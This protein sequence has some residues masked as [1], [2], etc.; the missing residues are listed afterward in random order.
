M[1]LALAYELTRR[2]T[3]DVL[4]LERAYL[5]AGASGRNG[6]G[7]RAQWATPTMIRLARR[8]LELCDRFA[9]DGGERLFR[10][11]DTC[12]SP[13]PLSRWRASRRTRS[14]TGGRGSARA[15]S[16]APRP[17]TW[18][19]SSTPALSRRVVQPGRRRGVPLAVPVGLR[20]P[21]RGGGRAHRDVHARHR[22]R[23]RGEARHGGGDR[24]RSCGATSWSSPPAPGRRRSRRCG[25]ALPNRPTRHEILVTEPMKPWW[26]RSACLGPRERALLLQSQRGELVGGMGRPARAGGSRAG[27]DVAIPGAVRARRDRLHPAAR[28]HAPAVWA[29]CYDVTPDNNPVLG[30]AGFENFHHALGSSATAS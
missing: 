6:G 20:R 7:V 16:V 26:A 4:V 13:P 8:S 23:D 24:P 29:G 18:C 25:V 1:G 28:R 21:C 19:R 22:F 15:S 10:E 3:R 14:C 5:N 11:V 9:V 17:S 2:G 30:P 12:S 27:V